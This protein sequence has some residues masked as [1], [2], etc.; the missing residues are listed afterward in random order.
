MV[1]TGKVALDQSNSYWVFTEDVPFG[2]PSTAAAIVL[3]TPVNGRQ[4][5]QDSTT[6]QTYG[7]WHSAQVQNAVPV[8]LSNSTAN[9]SSSSTN[10]DDDQDADDDT[11]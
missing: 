9:T 1:T 5:W 2:S 8:T 3:A 7:Q 4:A 11:N 10:Q 6:S